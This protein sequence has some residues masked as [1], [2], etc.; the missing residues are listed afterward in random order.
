MGNFQVCDALNIL[1]SLKSLLY[2]ILRLSSFCREKVVN[3]RIFSKLFTG[4]SNSIT[5][6]NSPTGSTKVGALMVRRMF[7]VAAMNC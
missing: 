5:Q 1:L 6:K 2:N 3:C 7:V 4:D